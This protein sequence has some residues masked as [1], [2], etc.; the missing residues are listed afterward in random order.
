MSERKN[1][2]RECFRL[3]RRRISVFISGADRV[4]IGGVD[5][6]KHISALFIGDEDVDWETTFAVFRGKRGS[7]REFRREERCVRDATKSIF[8][9]CIFLPSSE[10]A[11]KTL[12]VCCSA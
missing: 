11:S 5:G 9:L 7:S 1:V 3:H 2:R 8:G 12:L 4:G 10:G 6:T